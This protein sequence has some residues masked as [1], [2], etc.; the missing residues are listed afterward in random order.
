[1]L[2]YTTGDLAFA[3]F[4]FDEHYLAFGEDVSYGT[5]GGRSLFGC[6]MGCL[7]CDSDLSGNVVGYAAPAAYITPKNY[8]LACD[9]EKGYSMV[10]GRC[11]KTEEK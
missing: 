9:W 3:G 2:A 1:M 7:K 11:Y 8:C 6:G 5:V 4:D 10:G